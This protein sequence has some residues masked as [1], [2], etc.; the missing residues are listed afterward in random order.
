[1][2]LASYR[3]FTIPELASRLGPYLWRG[4]I[5]K[6]IRTNRLMNEVFSAH[7]YKTINCD[8]SRFPLME[9]ENGLRTMARNIRHVRKLNTGLLFLNFYFHCRLAHQKGR[10]CID[11]IP[12]DRPAWLPQPQ[13][14]RH[15]MVP[16]PAMPN[17][18]SLSC[19]S[20]HLREDLSHPSL[21][22]STNYGRDYLSMM[23]WITRDS[24]NLKKLNFQLYIE[25]EQ[26]I[27]LLTQM[28]S[29]MRNLK[30]LNLSIYTT[31]ALWAKLPMAVFYSCPS[32]LESLILEFG[33]IGQLDIRFKMNPEDDA[34]WDAIWDLQGPQPLSRRQEPLTRLQSL[35]LAFRMM[36]RLT[37]G[38]F[39]MLFSD[40]PAIEKLY[41]PWIGPLTD[42]VALG[43]FI[44]K[45]CS[46]L[47]DVHPSLN[48]DDHLLSVT[49]INT[50]APNT[51]RRL[52]TYDYGLDIATLSA[53]IQRHSSSL[54][55]VLLEG[56]KHLTSGL[57][58]QILAHC[59]ELEELRL[60]R[61]KP[62]TPPLTLADAAVERWASSKIKYLQ[63]RVTIPDLFYIKQ[64]KERPY[65]S[66]PEPITLTEAERGQFALLEKLYSQIG[67][68]R[69][70]EILDM[71]ALPE[72]TSVKAK[73]PDFIFPAFPAMLSLGTWGPNG[74]PGYLQLMRGMTRL[75][76]LIGSFE[77][78]S[79]ETVITVGQAEVEWM[80]QHWERLENV[81]FYSRRVAFRPC[82]QYM[83]EQRPTL[84][85][86]NYN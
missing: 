11:C 78:F 81:H 60:Y 76:K 82:F 43:L 54:R 44:G 6:L 28:L 71:V 33:I 8:S 10:A 70:M 3:F 26:Q 40:C 52:A 37:T 49:I 35:R 20:T 79:D 86:Y 66:R 5:V 63:L 62:T 2:R 65:F 21:D 31:E 48:Q 84:S 46:Q 27:P 56:Y 55:T 18:E 64:R 9:S 53:M 73:A 25:S 41:V 16:L 4:D 74:R 12:L 58:R 30:S 22:K 7:L 83:Q 68:Q 45:M 67:R 29:G 14:L 34:K 32:S 57:I 15:S 39:M 80:L 47:R 38:D 72:P 36:P 85:L 77:M 50:M 69:R 42:P 24:P 61:Y 59:S 1:M 19:R 17:L 13:A 51:L 23:F 75:R